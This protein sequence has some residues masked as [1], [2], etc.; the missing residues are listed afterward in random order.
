MG[1][2]KEGSSRR[3][4]G[5]TCLAG[6]VGLALLSGCQ[7]GAPALDD[8]GF[9]SNELAPLGGPSLTMVRNGDGGVQM[10]E[11]SET[12][13]VITGTDLADA[14]SVMVGTCQ[15]QITS[16]TATELRALTMCYGVPR[17][18]ATVSVTTPG[19][20]ASL[21]NALEITPF[22]ISP[23]APPTGGRG[24][25][26]SPMHLCDPT[27]NLWADTGNLLHL[28]GGTH[29]CNGLSLIGGVDIDGATD[30]ST[31]IRGDTSGFNLFLNADSRIRRLTF[32]APPEWGSMSLWSGAY[33]VE[34]VSGIR[35]QSNNSR[36]ITIDGYRFEGDGVALDLAA[37]TFALS[38]LV[39]DCAGG[40]GTGLQLIAPEHRPE[41]GS[42][43]VE[44]VEIS[45]CARGVQIN[46]RNPF[47]RT[48]VLE[49]KDLELVDNG[50]GLA[51]SSGEITVRNLEV[52]G[53][54]VAPPV[55]EYGVAF[56]GHSMSLLGGEIRGQ[57]VAGISQ[58]TS[59]PG[60]QN[61]DPVAY[62]FVDQYE[63]IGGPIGV[64]FSPY[65][66][67]TDI[68][69]RRSEIRDQTVASVRVDGEESTIDLGTVEEPGGNQL[70]VVSG[71]AIDDLRTT[72]EFTP[73]FYLDA[74]GTTLNGLGYDGNVIDG[75]ALISPDFR[76]PTWN[77]GIRF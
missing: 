53:D 31:V 48:P 2:V 71:F 28:L 30:G 63:I 46:R 76:I 33:L 38:D 45:R 12:V 25:F 42:G 26:E 37:E 6:C 7:E 35:I 41:A 11:S 77:S 17:G 51:V 4:L 61:P 10:R 60:G 73:S 75:P 21:P 23:T 40:A 49:L 70:S 24:T 14:T 74:H 15:P 43:T 55:S 47:Y 5:F 36:S 19:G 56:G 44:R 27:I 1:I 62:L 54:P 20:T 68:K 39:V 59:S 69:I 22:V 16:A 34:D 64:E 13:I 72:T 58:S 57:T 18:M 66:G 67:G 3:A 50:V 32:E 8:D 65:D 29:V 52:R 9:A